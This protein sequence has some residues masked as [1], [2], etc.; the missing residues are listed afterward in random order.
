MEVAA[1]AVSAKASISSKAEAPSVAVIVPYSLP[2]LISSLYSLNHRIYLI[3]MSM[4]SATR[5]ESYY[6]SSTLTY[7]LVF[8]RIPSSHVTIPSSLIQSIVCVHSSLLLPPHLLPRPPHILSSISIFSTLIHRISELRSPQR[9]HIL[10][11]LPTFLHL[12]A[13]HK[14]L[15]SDKKGRE[16]IMS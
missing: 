15:T 8:A 16:K 14:H 13:L 10:S 7:R 12:F 11:P 2:L 1:A 9:L 4:N 5:A 6:S 3:I